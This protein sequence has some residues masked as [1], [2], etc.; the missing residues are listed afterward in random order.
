[1]IDRIYLRFHRCSRNR[2]AAREVKIS[3]KGS[4][5]FGPSDAALSSSADI[6]LGERPPNAPT[7]E[8]PGQ[9]AAAWSLWLSQGKRCWF[10]ARTRGALPRLSAPA[11]IWSARR[12]GQLTGGLTR[13][14]SLNSNRGDREAHRGA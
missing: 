11:N 4:S 13:W 12:P 14:Q 6:P 8:D 2:W 9:R 1:M 5:F 7:D 10:H 3:K